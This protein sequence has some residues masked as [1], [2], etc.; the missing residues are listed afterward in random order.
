MNLKKLG[1]RIKLQRVAHDES[2][3]QLAEAIGATSCSIGNWE[4]GENEPRLRYLER[5]AVHYKMST[6]KLIEGCVK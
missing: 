1:K 2:Q 5:I 6:T 3:E 4:K